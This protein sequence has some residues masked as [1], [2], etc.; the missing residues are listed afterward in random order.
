MIFSKSNFLKFSL[1]LLF[2]TISIVSC[3]KQINETVITGQIDGLEDQWVNVVRHDIPRL[4]PTVIDS[5]YVSN[6]RFMMKVEVDKLQ[7][8]GLTISTNNISRPASPFFVEEGDRINITG[9]YFRNGDF[10]SLTIEVKGASNNNLTLDYENQEEHIQNQEEIEKYVLAN[11]N[12]QMCSVYLL[13]LLL[14]EGN[15]GVQEGRFGA[16]VLFNSITDDVKDSYFGKQLANKILVEKNNLIGGKAFNFIMQDSSGNK[17]ALNDIDCK[18]LILKFWMPEVNASWNEFEA[19]KGLYSKY[20][21]SGLEV[22]CVALE[23]E[24]F[25]WPNKTGE[26]LWY[27]NMVQEGIGD[28]INIREPFDQ[29]SISGQFDLSNVSTTFLLDSEGTILRRIENSAGH[30]GFR[31]GGLTLDDQGKYIRADVGDLDDLS[32]YVETLF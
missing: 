30:Y 20:H 28:W 11:P 17:F 25:S 23:Y 2:A 5:F 14:L 8:L 16:R 24:D 29:K 22:L 13:D 6:E 27:E 15:Q 32:N 19:L 10:H 26:E 12:S 18:Y 7:L 1:F 31:N 3:N 9:N 4:F 21:D